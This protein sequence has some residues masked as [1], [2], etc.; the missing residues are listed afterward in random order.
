MN[1]T[2]LSREMKTSQIQMETGR[3]LLKSNRC[4]IDYWGGQTEFQC[5][6]LD[7]AGKRI[8]SLCVSSERWRFLQ[9]QGGNRGRW[10]WQVP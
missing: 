8:K 6:Q 4:N 10:Q 5:H 7:M 1:P 3:K 9:L 2:S